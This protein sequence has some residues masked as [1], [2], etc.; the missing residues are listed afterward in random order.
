MQ[1]EEKTGKAGP[2]F[3]KETTNI[4]KG[5]AIILMFFHHFWGFPNWI[6]P[7]Y[8]GSAYENLSFLRFPLK[9]CVLIF[10]SLSGYFYYFSRKKTYSYSLQKI[11]SIL[12]RY[13]VCL[14]LLGTI[15]VLFFH[16]SYDLPSVIKE[17][18][19]IQSTTVLFNW[20]V[21]FYLV[22]MMLAPLLTRFLSRRP[23]L[24]ISVYFVALPLLFQVLFALIK[25]SFL[26]DLF[27]NCSNWLPAFYYGFLLAEYSVFEWIG[28]KFKK[29]VPNRI[30]QGLIAIIMLPVLTFLNAGSH[31]YF[32]ITFDLNSLLILL[33]IIIMPLELFFLIE[34]C[35]LIHAHS[36]IA[37]GIFSALGKVST[38]MWFLHS[39][40]FNFE[41]SF[42]Q[43]LAYF[44]GVP[45]ISVI[46]G[47]ILTFV[48][49]FILQVLIE[50][51]ETIFIRKSKRIS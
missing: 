25:V 5:V 49:A 9:I 26:P 39:A 38:L 16:H 31:I 43:P 40:F 50:R 7:E 18:C 23:A 34:I 27:L 4:I 35:K 12:T 22:C 47:L 36:K 11:R 3:S 42:F 45:I 21:A 13:W 2:Y 46:C 14:F 17:L 44:S 51:C 29:L 1:T 28:E 30:L 37:T 32:N 15:G 10:C 48:F 6:L 24:E 20:Y 8:G 33:D 41:R 19:A